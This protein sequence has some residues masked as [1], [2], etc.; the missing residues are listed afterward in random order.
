MVSYEDL[1]K[2]SSHQ[3]G[4]RYLVELGGVSYDERG[5]LRRNYSKLLGE[6]AKVSWEWSSMINAEQFYSEQ[7]AI[8]AFKKSNLDGPGV[9]YQPH[10]E[11]REL[12]KCCGTI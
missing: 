4:Y 10:Q 2:T 11:D 8:E 3:F 1:G 7:A 9:V 12:W 5:Y 6:E